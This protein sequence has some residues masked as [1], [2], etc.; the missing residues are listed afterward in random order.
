MIQTMLKGKYERG[1]QICVEGFISAYEFGPRILIR[2]QPNTSERLNW[3]KKLF[4]VNQGD[5]PLLHSFQEST[6][7]LHCLKFLHGLSFLLGF[8]LMVI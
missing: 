6:I 5:A 1:V 7:R 8:M 4:F 2:I 3:K